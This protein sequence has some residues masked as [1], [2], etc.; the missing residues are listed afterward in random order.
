MKATNSLPTAPF[1]LRLIGTI[2]ILSSL[3]DYLSVLIPPNFSDKAWFANVVTQVVD[4]G[5]I[6][7]VGLGFL[8]AGSFLENGSLAVGDR[9]KPFTTFRFWALLLSMLLG[10][11]FLVAFPLH[12][13]NTRQVSDQALERIDQQTRDAESQLNA[14]VQQ[15]QDQI[16]AALRDPNQAKQLDDQ[17]K[18]IDAA[19]A[20]G[21]LK[22]DQLTQAQR[23]QKE[24]QALKANPNSVADRAKEFR[25]TQLTKIREDRTKAESQ[26]RGEFWKTGVRVGISSLLLSLGYFVIG[27]S[28]LREMGILGGKRKPVMR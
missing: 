11:I 7:M 22:G 20:S 1:V 24:L 15:R 14:Q 25:N 21:Q 2:L 16:S 28:G 4:R 5:I 18:Q 27:W 10:L 26:A 8:F 9:A 19:I 17:L 3:V 12:L 13:N 6:P 23:A